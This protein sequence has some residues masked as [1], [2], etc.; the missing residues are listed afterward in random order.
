MNQLRPTTTR[1]AFLGA[2]LAVLGASACASEPA[3]EKPASTQWRLSGTYRASRVTPT[4]RFSEIT[5]DEKSFS[6]T[7][8]N[9]QA[10]CAIRGGYEVVEDRLIR[11]DYN[12]KAETIAVFP[13]MATASKVRTSAG[14][15]SL[16]GSGAVRPASVTVVPPPLRPS[17][18]AVIE[19]PP[20]AQS[21]SSNDGCGDE[22]SEESSS[23]GSLLGSG[24]SLLCQVVALLR[25]FT[26]ED[27]PGV[28]ANASTASISPRNNT[29]A[30]NGTAMTQSAP[31][32]PT[33]GQYGSVEWPAS[34]VCRSPMR[35]RGRCVD[36]TWSPVGEVTC[37]TA[38]FVASATSGSCSE[39]C[40]RVMHNN[41]P[42]QAVE[43]AAQAGDTNTNPGSR[44]G[45]T[46]RGCACC[47]PDGLEVD[48]G[49]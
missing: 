4:T 12:G 37:A 10:G 7:Q 35:D 18:G 46:V 23:E 40:A 42:A 41:C 9:C 17:C 25:E 30:S 21:S 45:R 22:T 38:R 16:S 48:E 28:P 33:C 14:K 24:G 39:I 32:S 47:A 19:P 49:N 26:M 11:L 13:N 1:I 8:A 43:P 29:P 27:S 20:P 5:F 3:E 2:I 34:A 15:K 6:A 44:C 36:G 31:A